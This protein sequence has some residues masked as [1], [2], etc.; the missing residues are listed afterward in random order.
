MGQNI[1]LLEDDDG[2]VIVGKVIQRFRTS[3][4]QYGFC[5]VANKSPENRDYIGSK[6]RYKVE[7]SRFSLEADPYNDVHFS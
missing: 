4:Q 5:R 3:V 1:F 7:V 6:V 2:T